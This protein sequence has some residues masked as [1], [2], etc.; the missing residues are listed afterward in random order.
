MYWFLAQKGN[1]IHK[2]YLEQ[3][4]KKNFFALSIFF[5]KVLSTYSDQTCVDLNQFFYLKGLLHLVS[6]LTLLSVNVF[7]KATNAAFWEI[8]RFN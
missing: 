4:T 1:G 3:F 7:R 8:V 5:F 6:V 2:I